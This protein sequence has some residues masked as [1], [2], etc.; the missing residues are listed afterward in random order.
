M[1]LICQGWDFYIK[2]FHVPDPALE[3]DVSAS[4]SLA[5]WT[6]WFSVVR[7][8]G[9]HCR[10]LRH[11]KVWFQKHTINKTPGQIE[12][13]DKGFSS[14]QG[15]GSRKTGSSATMTQSCLKAKKTAKE[16]RGP[17]SQNI[18]RIQ[19][20]RWKIT[21]FSENFFFFFTFFSTCSGH[22]LT[23]VCSINCRSY[24]LGV[25]G[26]GCSHV[27]RRADFIWGEASEQNGVSLV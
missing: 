14:G 24:G 1:P 12:A 7:G 15:W 22:R 10:T 21:R 27:G 16:R 5:L 4:V 8:C 26:W 6:R 13:K 18:Y 19:F 2:V 11:I 25:E 20:T 23:S 17:R 3:Q 9:R